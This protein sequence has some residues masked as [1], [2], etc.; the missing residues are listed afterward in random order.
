M[1]ENHTPRQKFRC[2]V[3][4]EAIHYPLVAGATVV[5]A[6]SYLW[7]LGDYANRNFQLVVITDI[8]INLLRNFN[9]IN[10]FIC[11]RSYFSA[12]SEFA[13]SAE[14]F[15][16]DPAVRVLLQISV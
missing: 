1:N 13:M 2:F 7:R 11:T 8:F 10:F 4:S 9:I 3:G 15:H 14:N 5:H 16:G 6:L 12:N